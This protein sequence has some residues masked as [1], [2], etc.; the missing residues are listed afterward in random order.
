M[1]RVLITSM[2]RFPMQQDLLLVRE[3][4][5]SRKKEERNASSWRRGCRRMSNNGGPSSS[6][7]PRKI[8]TPKADLSWEFRGG[9]AQMVHAFAE[10]EGE[11]TWMG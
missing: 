11:S 10:M 5:C 2:S 3:E 6:N 1:G 9:G 8:N 4:Q 7:N